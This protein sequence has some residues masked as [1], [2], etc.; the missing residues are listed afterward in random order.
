MS[1]DERI[2]IKSVEEFL[3]HLLVIKCETEDRLGE[4]A[5]CLEAH[6][7]QE[8]ADV[9]R[10][11]KELVAEGVSEI[12]RLAEGIELPVIKIWD[13]Q[14]YLVNSPENACIDNA[15]YLMNRRQALELAS[16]YSQRTCKFLLQAMDKEQIDEVQEIARQQ[17]SYEQ[18]F[19]IQKIER[20][21]TEVDEHE[22]SLCDDLDPPNLPE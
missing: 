19:V 11:I 15:H 22:T 18:Q 13:H 16:F 10:Q 14:W 3:A 20:W 6:H 4:L 7:N 2:L 17:L 21:L 9:F 1:I 12:E 8:V 5:D